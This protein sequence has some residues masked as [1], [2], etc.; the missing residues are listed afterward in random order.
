MY[1][2]RGDGT[3][4]INSMASDLINWKKLIGTSYA[5]NLKILI[6]KPGQ[7]NLLHYAQIFL[8]SSV[9]NQYRRFGT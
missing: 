2:D 9:L 7:N 3:P 1:V 5:K 8:I 4:W 6:E